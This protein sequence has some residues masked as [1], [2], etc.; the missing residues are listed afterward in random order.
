MFTQEND[1]DY[2]YWGLVEELHPSFVELISLLQGI[3]ENVN[4]Q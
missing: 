4:V 2:L 1:I 3:K